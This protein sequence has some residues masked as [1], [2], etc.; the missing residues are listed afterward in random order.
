[1]TLKSHEG[2]EDLGQHVV[3]LSVF[4]AKSHD[5]GEKGDRGK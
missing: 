2:N 3:F 4:L 5:L 1:M